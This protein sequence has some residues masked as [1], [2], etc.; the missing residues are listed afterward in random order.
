MSKWIAELIR[1]IVGQASPQIRKSICEMLNTLEAE[2]K[3]TP[4]PWDDVLV[5]LGKAVLACPEK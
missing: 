2:A 4:N 5:G 3:E 1:L